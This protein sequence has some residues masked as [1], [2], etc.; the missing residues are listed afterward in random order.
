M[1]TAT[2]VYGL[3]AILYELL[4]GR[5]PFRAETALA[6][7]LEVPQSAAAP[8]GLLNPRV[9][10]DLETICLKCLEKEPPR[11]YPSALE[12][13]EDLER[14]RRGEPILARPAT[15]GERSLRRARRHPVVAALSLV[16]GLALGLAVVTL[17][18]SNARIA[19][20]EAETA[21]ALAQERQA[22]GRGQRLLYLERVASASR[23]WSE[24]PARVGRDDC[25]TS[26]RR[27]S[28]TTGSGNSSTPSAGPTSEAWITA[29]MSSPWPTAPTVD[30]SPRPARAV[31]SSC[32][33]GG[34]ASAPPR[35]VRTR[36]AAAGGRSA[37]PRA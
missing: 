14:W 37:A 13:A 8:P 30:I 21:R 7:L 27:S 35:A 23:L 12:L 28:A 33:S 9:P 22:L 3:G 11:R 25:W 18:V 26:A 36:E 2:D 34:P 20:Q 4:T 6:T 32:G 24:Q 10:A 5:P 17:A 29:R 1:T 16:T 15:L 31:P 19:A